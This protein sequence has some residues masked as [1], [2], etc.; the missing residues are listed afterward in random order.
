M[1]TKID[2]PG[3]HWAELKDP[4][5]V[6]ERDRRPLKESLV[7]LGQAQR[8]PPQ[9]VGAASALGAINP[10]APPAPEPIPAMEVAERL[11]LIEAYERLCMSFFI[12]SWDFDFPVSDD[13]LLDLPS[14]VYNAL[15]KATA[16]FLKEVIPSQE[17]DDGTPTAP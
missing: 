14:P 5:D 11:D 4:M 13:A 12:V 7:K 17:S 3:G 16:P 1:T 9:P 6:T 2:L 10:F 15:E 8:T